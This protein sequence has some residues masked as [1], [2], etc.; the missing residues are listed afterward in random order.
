MSVT[1]IIVAVTDAEPEA[2]NEVGIDL[3]DT[4][5]FA[6]PMRLDALGQVVND[7]VI[8]FYRRFKHHAV[9]AMLLSVHVPIDE[10]DDAQ[11]VLTMVFQ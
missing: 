3:V 2:A 10:N 8:N 11:L 1:I 6:I 7:G 5:H 9:N 4:F